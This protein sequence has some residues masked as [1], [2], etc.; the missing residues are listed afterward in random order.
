MT[1]NV[2]CVRTWGTRQNTLDTMR[3][4]G[5]DGRVTGVPG[6]HSGFRITNPPTHGGEGI[7]SRVLV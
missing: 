3:V 4:D 1:D 6:G 7:E 2:A 5:S